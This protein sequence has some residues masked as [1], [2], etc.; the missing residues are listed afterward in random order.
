MVTK[1]EVIS[2]Y[3]AGFTSLKSQIDLESLPIQGTFPDWL[4]GSLLRNGP[5]LFDYSGQYFQHVF[6]GLA[7]LHRYTFQAGRVSY[8]NRFLQTDV[9]KET[10]RTKKLPDAFGTRSKNDFVFRWFDLF[11]LIMGGDDGKTINTNVS[12]VKIG[13]RF[14]ALTEPPKPTEFDPFTLKA[15]GEFKFSDTLA[16]QLSTPHPQ[17][18]ALRDNI[19]NYL[20]RFGP[21]SSYNVYRIKGHSQQRVLLCSIPVRE[22]AYMHSFGMTE[23]YIILSEFPF[24]LQPL[25]VLTSTKT[26]I[27]NYEWKPERGTRFYVISKRTGAVVGTFQSEA[28]F[29][30]HHVNSFEQDGDIFIDI[31]TTSVETLKE[32]FI[33]QLKVGAGIRGGKNEQ[34]RRYR[35][36]L[37]LGST[38]K[39]SVD[40]EVLSSERLDLPAINEG[41][42]RGKSYRYAY[43]V[44]NRPDYPEMV[45]NRLLK[46]DTNERINK[47]W[48][49]AGCYP[50]EP[51]F[52][53]KPAGKSEDDGLVLSVVLDGNAGKS[54][55]LALDGITFEE[56]G[57]ALL[58][59]AIPLE[60]HGLYID[61]LVRGS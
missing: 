47:D 7:M 12:I 48:F 53:A 19:Y 1:V 18:D 54:F 40:Y 52:V 49:E 21:T 51:I 37:A 61:G 41:L 8:R 59:H 17:Y 9:F 34:F 5:A 25:K 15:G 27:E 32:G 36:P 43:G 26:Y 2:K 38:K 56:V 50:N 39:F 14:L 45:S 28:F 24:V 23:N 30:F 58:P 10:I 4:N 55:L 6:D 60:F 35:I 13:T 16:G 42:K 20:T 3:Q 22:P 46:V 29:A 57:R 44:S 33:E 31:G 11:R